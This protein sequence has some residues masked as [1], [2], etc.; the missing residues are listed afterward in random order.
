MRNLSPEVKPVGPLNSLVNDKV[1]PEKELERVRNFVFALQDVASGNHTRLHNLEARLLGETGRDARFEAGRIPYPGV[2]GQISEAL[3]VLMEILH[4]QS[5]TI[6][7][8]E[9]L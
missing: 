2:V 1:E 9:R 7:G 8:L 5:D 4:S 3:V 6:E